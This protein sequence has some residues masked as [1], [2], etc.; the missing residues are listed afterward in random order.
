MNGSRRVSAAG[1]GVF[2]F[3]LKAS[4]KPVAYP[5]QSARLLDQVHELVRYKHCS[6]K[7]EEAYAYL[8]RFF[9]RW[10]GRAGVMQHPH[11]AGA[12]G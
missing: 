2:V 7:T 10:H 3:I 4:M 5:A 12:A 6:L 1:D 8:I 9:I 11:S